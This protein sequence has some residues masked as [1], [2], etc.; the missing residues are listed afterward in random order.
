MDD[1]D[2]KC[3]APAA[4]AAKTAPTTAD[5]TEKA[6]PPVV[7]GFDSSFGLSQGRHAMGGAADAAGPGDDD[8]MLEL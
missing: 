3:L 5:T 4:V 8:E 7:S 1:I 6:E 2:S